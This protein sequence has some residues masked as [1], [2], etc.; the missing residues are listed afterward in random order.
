MRDSLVLED[1]AGLVLAAG[2]APS[3]LGSGQPVGISDAPTHFGRVSFEMKLDLGASRL[4]GRIVFPETRGATWARLHVH[5]PEGQRLASIDP[6][7]GAVL[8]ADG[9]MLE[10]KAPRGTVSFSAKVGGKAP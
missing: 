2:T 6:G 9:S 7:A 10:W 5:L 1:G 3:W 8:S 4:T